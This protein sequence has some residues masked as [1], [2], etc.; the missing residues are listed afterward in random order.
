[1]EKERPINLVALIDD[2]EIDNFIGK[3]IIESTMLVNNIKVFSGGQKAIDF[4][5][6]NATEPDSLPE[7]IFLD[8]NI[9]EM[10]GF[11]FLAEYIRQKPRI[12]KKI[13]I[14][15]LTSL[16]V[17]RDHDRIKSI[18]IVLDFIEKPFTREKFKNILEALME[19]PLVGEESFLQK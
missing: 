15:V 4:L 9:P 1:M 19:K 14:Y 3:K 7:I 16:L 8:L 10:D 13:N 12:G 6:A 18:D 5:I 11:E 2:N 17:Q